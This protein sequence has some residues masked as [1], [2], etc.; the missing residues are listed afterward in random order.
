LDPSGLA[1]R[2]A[3]GACEPD[4]HSSAWAVVLSE[5]SRSASTLGK[6]AASVLSPS[7]L[8]EEVPLPF[9]HLL[10]PAVVVARR[11]LCSRL[12]LSADRLSF[13]ILGNVSAAAYR[14][15]ERGLLKQLCSIAGET[16]LS[17]FRRRLPLGRSLFLSP[18]L[19]DLEAG[20]TAYREFVDEHLN[21]GW[22]G[23]IRE[24]PVL[25]RLV[26]LAV[27]LWSDAT[28]ELLERLAADRPEL[29]RS[30][31]LKE[32]TRI[33]H[34]DVAVGDRHRMGRSVTIVEFASGQKVVYKPK[35]LVSEV[36]FNHLLEWCDR[37]GSSPGFRVTTVLD[38]SEYG[39]VEHLAH[40]PCE[41]EREAETY[42]RRAGMLLCVLYITRATDCHYENLIAHGDHPVLI[43][44]ETLLYPDP[45]PLGAVHGVES[46]E[47]AGDHPLAGSVLRNG[48]LPRW[49]AGGER[50]EAYD[51]SG[52]GG[53]GSDQAPREIL[54]WDRTNTDEMVVRRERVV[55]EDRQNVARIGDRVLSA[56]DYEAELTEGFES[57]YRLLVAHRD[58]LCADDGPLASMRGQPVR[59]VYRPTRIYNALRASSWTPDVLRNGVEYGIHLERLARA[60]LASRDRP[61]S[62]PVLAAEVRA[63]ERMDVP[64]FI[65]RTDQADLELE[66]GTI[67]SDAFTGPSHQ[68]MLWLV[69]RMS[70]EDLEQQLLLIR[71]T[72]QAKAARAPNGEVARRSAHLPA[73]EPLSADELLGAARAIGFEIQD[74]AMSSHGGEGASWIGMTYL[75]GADRYQ[76]DLLNDS[77]YDGCCGVAVFLAALSR[78]TGERRFARL[79]KRSLHALRRRL[80]DTDS[81]SRRFVARMQGLGGAVGFGSVIY[82]LVRTAELLDGEDPGLVDDAIELANWLTPEV[83]ADDER[84]DVLSGAAG[85]LLA[86][87]ALFSAS[88]EQS[89][90]RTAVQCGDHLLRERVDT[91][92]HRAWRTV[93]EHPLTGF[94]HG[95]A[96]ISYALVRLYHLTG[97]R[98]YL[99]AA[100]EGIEFERAVYSESHGNWPDLRSRDAADP[101][102]FPVKWCH[103]A[104]G[105]ALARLGCMPLAVIPGVER[106]ISAGLETTR[107]HYLKDAD[108]LCCGNLGRTETFLVAADVTGDSAWRQLGAEGAARVIRRATRNGGF[109]VF[110]SAESYNPGFFQG[111]AGIGYQLLRLTDGEL[112]SVLLWE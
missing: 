66:D 9:E 68:E 17:E 35:P 40:L 25:G 38:R 27:E 8:S 36:N 12:G 102:G 63:M 45:T 3:D 73:S 58:A 31:G 28:A 96:G 46:G 34:L 44:A 60:Y 33:A 77:L 99:D 26:G 24:Y 86:L 43:D 89:V 51:S 75:D 112:P 78:V 64:L 47:A 20:D 42:Y 59:F 87:L 76:L 61:I 111:T 83:I 71:G 100:L 106:E 108:F 80:R 84:L 103:G 88:G 16:L 94:S 54:T 30:F 107:E 5:I 22:L 91:F 2:L 81:R 62:W 85:A 65:A 48:L 7:P 104:S 109:R 13:P 110:A 74:R 14:D 53:V 50:G 18:E 101:T 37:I 1:W 15:L 69:T 105:I 55:V 19:P 72:L 92:G 67:V 52:L 6:R 29:A 98:S 70:E 56:L 90:L 79:S 11:M 10:L 93:A 32:P 4:G 49:Q 39:W 95:A 23:L 41:N 57:M 21:S 82:G 97:N